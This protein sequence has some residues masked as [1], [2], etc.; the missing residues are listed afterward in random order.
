MLINN[1][2]F[3]DKLTSLSKSNEPLEFHYYLSDR[4][5]YNATRRQNYQY[6]LQRNI[7][8]VQKKDNTGNVCKYTPLFPRATLYAKDDLPTDVNEVKSPNDF[9]KLYIWDESVD[10][11]IIETKCYTGREN[12]PSVRPNFQAKVGKEIIRTSL[13]IMKITGY[14]SPTQ[15]G[16]Y[17]VNCTGKSRRTQGTLFKKKSVRKAFEDVKRSTNIAGIQKLKLKDF[18]WKLRSFFNAFNGTAKI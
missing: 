16:M 4:R 8:G 17:S 3:A 15:K 10:E 14:F 6:K 9:I 2:L 1:L 12:R 7:K 5:H 11:T 18:F 13:A